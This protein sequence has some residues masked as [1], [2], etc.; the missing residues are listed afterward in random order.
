MCVYLMHLLQWCSHSSVCPL[1]QLSPSTITVLTSHLHRTCER[2]SMRRWTRVGVMNSRMYVRKQLDVGRR[3]SPL[4]VFVVSVKAESLMQ[5]GAGGFAD[6]FTCIMNRKGSIIHE[7]ESLPKAWC[8]C[9]TLKDLP[10][11]FATAKDFEFATVSFDVL[12]ELI[13][14]LWI[15]L[16]EKRHQDSVKFNLTLF[17]FKPFTFSS[18]DPVSRK[19]MIGV[20]SIHSSGRL[21]SRSLCSVRCG[22]DFSVMDPF[23]Y[24]KAPRS[25]SL[26][27][28]AFP[29]LLGKVQDGQ[30]HPQTRKKKQKVTLQDHGNL[31]PFNDG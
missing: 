12:F 20:N 23:R 7:L 10:K 4:I 2:V 15:L 14:P 3:S 25:R 6:V 19:I 13:P 11:S 18:V 26:K 16:L 5:N 24:T 27:P 21:R 9:D 1:L 29:D 31:D 8:L 17:D 28:L 30:N 22:R